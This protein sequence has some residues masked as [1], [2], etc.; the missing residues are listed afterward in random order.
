MD[1]LLSGVRVIDA[2][3]F[4]AGPASATILADFG[5]DVIKVEPPGGDVYRTLVGRHPVPYHW[6]LTSRNKRSICL[7][8]K[9]PEGQEVLHRLV[10]D[11]DVLLTNFL[12]KQLDA[13]RMTY[14]ELKAINP[15]LVFAQMTGYGTRGPEVRRR[16]FDVTAWWARSGI[17]ELVRGKGQAPMQPAPGMGDHTT[18]LAMYGAIMT[19]LYRRERTGEGC[20][21]TTSLAASGAWVNG[22]ALQGVIAGVDLAAISQERGWANPFRIAYP[23][24]D[25]LYVTLAIIN[26]GREWPQLARALDHPEWLEDPRFADMRTLLRN[27]DA[28][29][30]AITTATSRWTQAELMKRLDAH[31]VTCGVVA[32]MSEVV[33]DEQLR[34][35]DIVVE[36]DD[37]GEGYDYTINSPIFLE[38]EGKRPPKRAPEI[39]AHTEEVLAEAGYSEAEIR[40]L[41]EAEVAFGQA[42]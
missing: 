41:L 28:L 18:S 13:F 35:N 37:S 26:T 32:R 7:D 39:G 42:N 30:E 20:Q 14:E 10:A 12:G 29:I 15:R 19:G 3:T 24:S 25:G 4:L 27:R 8:L 9:R 23:T 31:E 5:A 6:Q 17:M 22:M 2:A 11:A 21:V 34:A 16:A 33:V 40:T 1:Y 36:T 38:E